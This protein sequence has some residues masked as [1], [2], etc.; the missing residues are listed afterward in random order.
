MFYFN[1]QTDNDFLFWQLL[2]PEGR[3]CKRFG[4]GAVVIK[5]L[6]LVCTLKQNIGRTL[7]GLTNKKSIRL[8]MLS[9]T[10][11]SVKSVKVNI[12]HAN[13]SRG[14]CVVSQGGRMGYPACICRDADT[15]VQN[16]S[17]SRRRLCHVRRTVLCKCLFSY[18]GVT[19][20]VSDLE[21]GTNITKK[22]KKK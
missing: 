5:N 15:I 22:W 10:Y 6:T 1:M 21:D 20:G 19:T 17:R 4:S 9:S 2:S 12:F 7:R 8:E 3:R 16:W 14:R 11:M 18:H 13:I